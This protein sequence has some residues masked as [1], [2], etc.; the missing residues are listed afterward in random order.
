MR[1]NRVVKS[2]SADKINVRRKE[3][4][5]SSKNPTQI[6]VGL[7]CVV[8]FCLV[9][10]I[11]FLIFTDRLSLASTE[12]E[13][14]Q[15]AAGKIIRVPKGGNLQTAINLAG[16]GDIIELQ[17]GATYGEIVLPKKNFTDFVTIRSSAF[18]QL[19]ENARIE[20]SKSNLFA[21]IV[22]RGG[23]GAVET[24]NGAHHFRFVGIEFAS[25]GKDYVYNL[26]YLGTESDSAADVP[27]DFEFDRCYFHSSKENVTRRGIALNG[28]NATIKNSYFEGFAFSGEETQAI[29]GWTGTKNARILNNYI[30]GG[31]ENIMFGGGEPPNAEMIPQDIIISGNHFNKPPEWKGKVSMKCLFELK[32]AKRV[33]FTENYLE[34]N[35]IGSALR[36]T[37]RSEDGKAP[38]NTIEDVVIKNNVINGAGE[39][40]NI[41]GKDDYYSGKPDSAKGQTLKRLT[42]TNNLFLNIG[43]GQFEGSGY[44]VQVSD[45]EQ[46]TISKNTSFNNGNIA[47]FHGTLP[48]NLVFRDNIIAHGE[49]G[50]HGLENVKSPAAQKFFQNNVFVNNKNVDV[51]Y[52]SFPP[53][54]FL[55]GSIQQIGFISPNDFRLNSQSKLKGKASDGKNIGS[56]LTFDAA[57]KSILLTT[58]QTKK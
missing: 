14:I 22:S 15:N 37:L 41:L 6:L 55:V 35:W 19:P 5:K 27:H 30:E 51:A 45:G 47:T 38:F 36:L 43:G 49:Y 39:G 32:N 2:M 18:E 54:N 29:C 16:G 11:S 9:G 23:K 1:K 50:I 17:A 12:P 46:I 8:L 33:E 58:D 26:I 42:I 24:Q 7:I 4:K 52:A 56:D 44:F 53:N 3:N 13:I 31:A 21:K 20:P 57:K 28:R 34:N 40:I 48:R 10:L 25:S